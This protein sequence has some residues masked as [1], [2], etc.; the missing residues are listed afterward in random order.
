M[1]NYNETELFDYIT[2]LEVFCTIN[3]RDP[4]NAETFTGK[5]GDMPLQSIDRLLRYG[6][7][8]HVNDPIGGDDI[9]KKTK[10]L[11]ASDLITDLYNGYAGKRRAESADPTLR[12]ALAAL[13]EMMTPAEWKIINSATN[14]DDVLMAMLIEHEAV[15]APRTAELKE[16][17][18]K[19]K[20]GA[21]KIKLSLNLSKLGLKK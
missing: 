1:R 15:V 12:F 9:D 20:A 11:M 16:I 21:S 14:A 4:F 7:Q 13:K 6:F 3:K 5:V 18:E 2:K 19:K 10:A 17:D 8:R